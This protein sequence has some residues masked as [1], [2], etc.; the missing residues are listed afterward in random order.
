MV[1]QI[2]IEQE[3]YQWLKEKCPEAEPAPGDVG[4]LV[5]FAETFLNGR[6][7]KEIAQ[8][9]L[10]EPG[11]LP[12]EWFVPAE[13]GP[14]GPFGIAE[15]VREYVKFMERT[16]PGSADNF[17][18]IHEAVCPHALEGGRPMNQAS[19]GEQA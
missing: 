19:K 18:K 6:L 4:M 5:A 8:A 10:L 1:T 15:A 3:A 9:L 11:D 14:L 17:R 13:P 16:E 12:G 7:E 2:S